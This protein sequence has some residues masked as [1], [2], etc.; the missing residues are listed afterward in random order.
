MCVRRV[1]R[2]A[3]H[4][5]HGRHK[6]LPPL[7]L[8]PDALHYDGGLLHGISRRR[9]HNVE[10]PQVQRLV[11]PRT[12]EHSVVVA[13]AIVHRSFAIAAMPEGS[14]KFASESI[15]NFN[16][17]FKLKFEFRLWEHLGKLGLV[18]FARVYKNQKKS[19]LLG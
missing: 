10:R 15:F 8:A 11:P 12:L 5:R 17:I 6:Y 18:V 7:P 2:F 1:Y 9:V 13:P 16:F 19:G 14:Q 4:R 3:P